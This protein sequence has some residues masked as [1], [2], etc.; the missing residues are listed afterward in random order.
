MKKIASISLMS[1]LL[2]LVLSLGVCKAATNPFVVQA[3]SKSSQ[4]T[5]EEPKPKEPP[6]EKISITHHS[7]KINGMT[8]NYK[9][10]AGC[11]PMKDEAGELKANIFFTSYI[12]NGE[13]DKSQRP[14]TFA[15][16]GGPGAASVF[17]HL[18]A[19]GPKR[20]LLAD[21]KE[22]LPPPYKLVENECTWLDITDLVFIDPV[23]TGYS[24]AASGEDPK[25]FWGVEEDIHSVGEFIRLY[26]TKYNRWL[27]PKFIAGESYGTTRA[28]GLSSYLQNKLGINLNGLILISE[29]LNFQ[30]IVFTPGNDLPYVLFLPT[31][32]TTAWYHHKL[33]PEF[34]S[35]F[36]RTVE[37]VEQF[38]LNEYW[39]ALAKGYLLSEPERNSVVEKLEKYTGLSKTYIQKS[40]LRVSRD[41]F[42]KELL[43][44][45]D[46]RM[47]VLDSRITGKY[48]PQDFTQDPSVFVVTGLL[49]ATWNDY[50]RKELK[51]ETERPYEI[52][53]MKANESWNWS[54]ATGGLGYV[55][56]VDTLQ[57]AMS[58]NQCLKVLI[59]S[60]TYD[61]DTPYFAAKY[62]ANR[63]AINPILRKNLTLAFYEAGHQMYTHLPA[64]RKLKTDV[65]DFFRKAIPIIK[66]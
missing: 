37:A 57:Q 40:N 13:E 16:N 42:T 50:V 45:E 39:V 49:T 33:P 30:S 44:Q 12:K 64:L 47:G 14:I 59:A 60:G 3:T 56:V 11:L 55:N 36:Q 20:I 1:G 15:F 62:A 29:A 63:L 24:R 6:Q 53:S 48:T 18:G 26:L 51:Y 38:A 28:A 41:D 19:L 10:F 23:G 61:L 5:R 8:L 66:D 27:S 34:Q 58:E 7:I 65:E 4:Q 25:K 21:E 35:N 32:T 17:L 31:Y 54:S 43:R 22:A 9:V 46:L 52:L 2:I